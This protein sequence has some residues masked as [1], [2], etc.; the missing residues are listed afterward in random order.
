MKDNKGLLKLLMILGVIGLVLAIVLGSASAQEVTPI[1]QQLGIS[2]LV[3]PQVITNSVEAVKASEAA[4]LACEQ[5]LI[6]S[7][8]LVD[9]YKLYI[10]SIFGLF[11]IG[12][13]ALWYYIVR[14][15]KK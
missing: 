2:D 5:S 13:I 3:S 7:D 12:N 6:R 4:K 8:R 1:N 11:S 14:G 15:V 10:L 9:N